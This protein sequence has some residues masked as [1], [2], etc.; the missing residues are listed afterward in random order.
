VTGAQ[1]FIGQALI[2]ALA[3]RGREVLPVA[4]SAAA[5]GEVVVGDIGPETDWSQALIGVNKVVHAAARVHVMAERA[6]DPLAAFRRVNVEGTLNLARQAMAVGVNRFVF[7]SSIGVN[8]NSNN[9]PFT[10][11]DEPRPEEPYAVSKLEAE[12]ALLDLAAEMEMEV[13]IIRPPLVYGPHAPGNFGTLLRWVKSGIPLP[14]GAIHNR[15]S[16]VALD[17]LVDLIITCLDHPAAANQTFLVADGEDL[18]TTELLRRTAAALGRP[19]RLVPVPQSFLTAGLRII[20]KGALAQRLCGSLQV[21]TG[22]ARTLL[23]WRPPLNVDQG[24]AA[25]ARPF[26][27]S[28]H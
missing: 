25:A 12:N 28:N 14:L 23:G 24:L 3:A 4:R 21:D 7:L 16:L 27:E 8:G 19:A 2:E 11:D 1:G 13:V 9:R 15:R 17:N 20:G 22:K 10:E 6:T 18:S 26:F 5:K